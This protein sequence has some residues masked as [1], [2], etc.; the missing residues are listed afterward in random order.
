MIKKNYDDLAI[1]S[2]Q[3]MEM[4]TREINLLQQKEREQRRDLSQNEQLSLD[5]REQ[6]RAT[7]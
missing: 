4:A 6:L 5:L 2:N 7:V 3:D 1:K